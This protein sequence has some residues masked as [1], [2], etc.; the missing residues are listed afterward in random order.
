MKAAIRVRGIWRSV[1]ARVLSGS[2]P[3]G[4]V[5]TVMSSI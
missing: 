1:P 2:P 3:V 5:V 4:G